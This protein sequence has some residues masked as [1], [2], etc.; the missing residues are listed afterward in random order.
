MVPV[1]I[2]IVYFGFFCVF[3]GMRASKSVSDSKSYF[4]ATGQ[5]GWIAV[6]CSFT[7]AP[8]GGG[9][10]SSLW[11]QAGGMG[12]G[13]A[14]WG[15]TSGGFMVPIFLLWFGPMFLKLKVQTFPQA[16]GKVFGPKAKIWNSC[17]APAGWLGITMS[18]LFGTAMAIYTLS[19]ARLSVTACVLIAGL[20]FIIYIWFAGMLQAS[21]MNIINAVMLIIGSFMAIFWLGG[22]L[23]GGYQAV[24]DYYAGAGMAGNTN[25]FNFS[26]TVLW[27]QIVPCLIL[28]LFSVS[29][30]HAMYQPMLGAKDVNAIRKGA[31]PGG[32]I[33]A[34]ACLP[35][36][37]LGVTAAA[38]PQVAGTD[39][40][41]AVPNLVL[42]YL[43][44]VIVGFLMVALLCALLSTGS[45]MV[46]AIAH[47]VCDDLITPC[48]TKKR[49]PKQQMWLSRVVCLIVTLAAALPSL[50]VEVFILL[51]FWC[52]SLSLPIFICYLIGMLWK[53]NRTAAWINLVASLAVNCWWTFALPS[54][55]PP[56]FT[57]SFYP[58]FVVT[59]GLG[60]IL[61]LVMPGEKGI[62]RQI[63]EQEA[64]GQIPA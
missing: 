12:M 41:T 59:F 1:I 6:M 55:C 56:N 50:K 54:W 14:W 29:S 45:G 62:L 18:E 23:P 30:E 21:Y 44:P 10:T 51:F 11:Q 40:M 37:I 5:L 53:V 49:T 47:V 35:F 28:C 4:T 36:V 26:P 3:F 60:I 9:H 63:K 46:L 39:A 48:S 32:M 57:L 58:V 19:G 31:L 42:A 24:A 34:M 52:F 43:P 7:L 2:T 15:I 64:A 25:L 27:G 20:L 61:A 16:L 17:V 22:A 8:L 38:L 13:A 33:N